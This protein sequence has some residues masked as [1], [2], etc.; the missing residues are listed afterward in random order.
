MA[1]ISELPRYVGHSQVALHKTIPYSPS[2]VSTTSST[3]SSTFSVD[4]PSSQ[5]SIS[6]SSLDDWGNTTYQNEN[7]NPSSANLQPL[8][9]HDSVF[10]EEDSKHCPTYLASRPLLPGVIAPNS[11]QNP[12]RTQRL[13]SYESQDG[14][15]INQ[16][17]LAPPSLVR[18]SERK[19]NFVESLV[20]KLI[21]RSWGE[22]TC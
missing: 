17:P 1:Y 21:D 8:R 15:K 4:A 10:S 5:S 11:R 22:L 18:Q 7:E 14:K 19:D 12:R 2:S 3:S 9:Q 13:N 6:C 16:C 20:G